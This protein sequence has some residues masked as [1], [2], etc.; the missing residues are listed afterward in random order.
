MMEQKG[1][2]GDDALSA[3][4]EEAKDFVKTLPVK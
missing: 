3:L 4:L 1:F 2:E